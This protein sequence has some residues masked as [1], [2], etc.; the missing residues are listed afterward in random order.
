MIEVCDA[1]GALLSVN[2]QMRFMDQYGLPKAMLD[3]SEYGGCKSM[4]VVGGN[5]GMAMN[6]LHYF[7]AF[8]FVM[9]EELYEVTAWFDENE[10]SNPRGIQ[11][12]DC[13]GSIRAT[14]ALG[15]RLYVEIGSDQGHGLQVIYA[16]RN[17]L[18]S[19]NELTGEMFSN[20]RQSPF[21]DLPTTR[22]G[23]PSD[24]SSV[25]IAAVEVVDSSAMVLKSL[26]MN[27]TRVTGEEGMMAVKALIAAYTSYDNKSSTVRIDSALDADRIFPWA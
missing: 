1:H 15:K 8:R 3:N 10:I 23:M 6:A 17:G 24:R 13:S 21:R 16:G 19:I 22:Y 26:L 9:D 18:I 11:F 7:E 27:D 14:T 20:V 12:K 2:H 25:N 5:I 4:T